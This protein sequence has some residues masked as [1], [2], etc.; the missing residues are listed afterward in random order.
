MRFIFLKVGKI[1]FFLLSY[2]GDGY[3]TLKFL[4]MNFLWELSVL[5]DFYVCLGLGVI[6]LGF[7]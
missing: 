7:C 1:E 3:L 2:R 6:D 5:S 4:I